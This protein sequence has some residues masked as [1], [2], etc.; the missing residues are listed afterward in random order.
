MK[1]L[2]AEGLL[3]RLRDR[4]D[5]LTTRAQDV[6]ERQRTIRAAIDWSYDLVDSRE[7]SLFAQLSVFPGTFSLAAAEAICAADL[8]R[9]EALADS[10]LLQPVG[11]QRFRMLEVVRQ[12]AAERLEEA[13]GADAAR[14]RHLEHFIEFAE[15]LQP[16]LRGAAAE[17]S[18]GMLE[19]EHD[20]FRAALGFARDTA[21]ELQLRLARALQRF[22]SLHGYL[23]EGREW[24]ESALRAGG[25]QSPHLRAQAL[26]GVGAIAW[27]QHDVDAAERFAAEAVEIFR[28]LGDDRE[29][30][31]P[32]SVLGA[33]A[34]RQGD[35]GKALAFHEESGQLARRAD[36]GYGVAMSLN[37]QAYA[38]W[39][40]A[41]VDRAGALWEE[42]LSAAR[43]AGTTEVAALA[44][45]GLGDVALA[46]G[47][48]ES[49]GQR[50]RDALASFVQLGFPELQADTCVCLAAVAKAE[51][52]LG[53]A[54]QLLGV[55]A[56][57]RQVSGAPEQPDQ[58][59]LAYLSE[60]TDAAR[61]ELGDEGFDA[62]FG[63]GRT[64]VWEL[65]NEELARRPA[66][67][68]TPTRAVSEP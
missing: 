27:R 15:E 47:T 46:R 7:R 37:N 9:L 66:V 28:E 55:A 43:E 57:L 8:T 5:M 63:R 64:S 31:G 42:C 41:D 23:N 56:S 48:P 12:R 1:L 53:R 62:A 39:M 3:A 36:D 20:Q 68:A 40:T 4:L 59:I 32:L 45:S 10:S 22:W 19:Q 38:A 51:S 67:E 33:V 17:T 11:E 58:A 30:V 34:A 52:E 54:A 6:P 21:Q 49:A 50:F 60:V 35:Y 13:G 26:A 29:L 14:H 24:L 65:V 61:A 2:S 44:T 16:T 18:F 25:T